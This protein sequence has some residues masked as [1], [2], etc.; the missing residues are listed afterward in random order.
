MTIEERQRLEADQAI[1]RFAAVEVLALWGG[2][3]RSK[4]H[5]FWLYRAAPAAIAEYNERKGFCEIPGKSLA[6]NGK[7]SGNEWFWLMKDAL[8]LLRNEEAQAIAA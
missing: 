7:T 1:E 5:G 4:G 8:V 2:G 6:N 3:S